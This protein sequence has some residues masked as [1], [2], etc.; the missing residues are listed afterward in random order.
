MALQSFRE[1]VSQMEL[2]S[3]T[4]TYIGFENCG[5]GIGPKSLNLFISKPRQAA[6]SIFIVVCETSEFERQL[7][8]STCELRGST[9]E[10]FFNMGSEGTVSALKERP[11]KPPIARI[12]HPQLNPGGIVEVSFGGEVLF[13]SRP[14]SPSPGG[15]RS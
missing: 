9:C 1:E 7:R 15:T 6:Q 13:D 12:Q 4:N 5:L 14:G 8:G 10:E 11:V 3:S 2:K